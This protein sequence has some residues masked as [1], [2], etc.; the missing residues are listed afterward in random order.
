MAYYRKVLEDTVSAINKCYEK[1]IKDVNVRR[2]RRCNAIPS[3]ERSKINFISR[4]L[5]DLNKIGYLEFIGR[6]SPKKYK[7]I[8]PIKDLKEIQ[9]ELHI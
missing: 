1:D 2:I 3:T 9:K 4:A 7:I 6:N 5:D 8:K